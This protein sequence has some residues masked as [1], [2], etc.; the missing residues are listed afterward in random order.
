MLK[1]IV[2]SLTESNKKF[3]I[4]YIILL[5]V[6]IL[7]FNFFDK[8]IA[9][10]IKENNNSIKDIFNYITYFGKGELYLVPPLII[11]FIYKNKNKNR[12]TASLIL[13]NAVLFS[14]IF[15][16]LLKVIFARYRPRMLDSGEYGFSWFDFGHSVASFPSGHSATAL[17]AFVVFAL[18]I[19]KFRNLF[20]FVGIII[21]LS[22]I[23]VGAH[24]LS[25][26]IVGGIIGA[27]F[28]L[29]IYN[30]QKKSIV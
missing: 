9:I 25:D 28:A 11:Y 30:M 18:I 1:K 27:S 6:S 24:Y 10:L 12:A 29:T 4:Y 22:R 20:I 15:V 26:V 14:G 13:F 8:K 21:A 3:V 17:S 2:L 5:I 23:V 16:N 19:P 7:L